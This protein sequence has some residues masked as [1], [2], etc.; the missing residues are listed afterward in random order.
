MDRNGYI[1]SYLSP[2]NAGVPT[3]KRL[4]FILVLLCAGV[5]NATVINVPSEQPTIQAGIDAA[6][7]GDTVLI[8]PGFYL[9]NVDFASKAITLMSSGGPEQT[10]IQA[11][12]T[13][14]HVVTIS[15]GQDSLTILDG[16][17]IS[18]TIDAY[19]VFCDNSAPIIRNCEVF[20][21]QSSGNGAGIVVEEAGAKIRHCTI[22]DN[23]GANTGGGVFFYGAHGGV[24]E[25]SNCHIYGN[26]AGAGPGIGSTVAGNSAIIYRNVLWGNNGM[27]DY[28]GAIYVRRNTQ[29]TNNTINGNYKGITILDGIGVIVRNNIVSLNSEDGLV[30]ADA[31]FDYND[32]WG[33][34][35]QNIIG[36]NGISE[37]PQFSNVEAN[38][39]RLLAFS[40]CIDAGDPDPVYNDP[41]YTRSDIGALYFD[42]GDLPHVM[43]LSVG[44]SSVPDFVHSLYPQISWSF[45][46]T[47]VTSQAA[48]ELQVGSDQDWTIAEMWDTGEVHASD[49]VVI[50]DGASLVNDSTYY[51]RVRLSNGAMWGGWLESFFTVH[52][53]NMY[54]PSEFST[55]QSA[56]NSAISYDTVIVAAGVYNE[57]V[58][59]EGKSV[60]LLSSAGLGSTA[61]ISAIDGLPVI[62][63]SVGVD[64]MASVNGF[65]ISGAVNS[66]AIRCY[67]ASPKITGNRVSGNSNTG[68]GCSGIEVENSQYVEISSNTIDQNLGPALKLLGA[69]DILLTANAFEDNTAPHGPSGF[70]AGSHS[71]T[72]TE[73]TLTGN[74]ATDFATVFFSGCSDV[75]VDHNTMLSNSSGSRGTVSFY[76]GTTGLTISNNIIVGDETGYGIHNEN[77]TDYEIG[78]N[79]IW[80]NFDGSYFGSLPDE[81][82]ISADPIMCDTTENDYSLAIGSPCLGSASD[83][84][85]IGAFGY[86]CDLPS[87][88]QPEVDRIGLDLPSDSLHLTNHSP[89]LSW[90]YYDSQGRSHTA[91]EIEVGTD[92][93]WSVAEMWQP[94]TI[95]GSDTTIVYD[96]DLLLDGQSYYVRVRVYNDTLWSLWLSAIFRMNS[97]PTA[98]VLASPADES[99]VLT[100][101]PS[102]VVNNA[103]DAEGDELRYDFEIH[104]DS[105]MSLLHAYISGV[106][107]GGGQTSW[108]SDSLTAENQ[109]LWWRARASDGYENGSWSDSGMF[110]LNAY[111]EAPEEFAL[112]T[113]S[114]SESVFDLTPT[115]SWDA[116]LDPDPGDSLYYELIIAIDSGFF[117]STSIDSIY[118]TSH[119]LTSDLQLDWGY[120]WK[121][122]AVDTEGMSAWS[123]DV[124]YFHTSLPWICGDADASGGVDIDDAVYLI[125]YIFASGPAPEPL[126]SGDVDLSGAVDIDDVVYL[127]NYIF[128]GGPEPCA[129]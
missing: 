55:I 65:T 116:A 78:Y 21:C 93:E 91:S 5:S 92:D 49:S 108:T 15:G 19:G 43:N 121:V 48:Y 128:G 31:I 88:E 33:N 59:I 112:L 85:D 9:E 115:F 37:N 103:A 32:V 25:I 41:D 125:A 20:N 29:I 58:V 6:V 8:S 40:P 56:V 110:L 97:L 102:L 26:T 98:P 100:G 118:S 12:N 80:N 28:G 122:Q 127:I 14:D 104:L 73:N 50:Y 83:G 38:D 64:S 24:L 45:A 52:L 86:G 2:Q 66:P 1:F 35:S 106:Y 13:V 63:L 18:G 72:Y 71:L 3:M 114:D 74:V 94:P 54:V 129:T 126:E 87:P 60:S 42:R 27:G 61:L 123:S 82:N 96:G 30:P 75:V 107:E 111:N 90:T 113:P 36:A 57:N 39:Y 69:S 23:T 99:I 105:S 16:F 124:F 47:G 77:C 34:G 120:W 4:I 22:R 11:Y 76:G 89:E 17:S 70:I 68:D 53:Q 117:F 10:G 7:N 44:P 84:G 109:P 81:G 95:Q 119:E 51:L 46:D 79:D 62:S 67:N 101:R